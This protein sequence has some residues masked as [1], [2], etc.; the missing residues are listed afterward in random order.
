MRRSSLLAILCA[1]VCALT[2]QGQFFHRFGGGRG[3]AMPEVAGTV[4]L[5]PSETVVGVPCHFVFAFKGGNAVNV[6]Q[7]SGLPNEGIEYLARELEPY[8]DN[9]YRLPVRFLVPMTN[10]TL[11]VAVA[12]MQTVE[13]G[14]G[15]AFVSSFSSSF[16]KRLPPLR[17]DVR[18]LP[19][20][21]RP[22]TFSGAV[23]TKFLLTQTLDRDHVR[24]NDLVTATYHLEFNGYCPSNIWP[25]VDHLSREFKAYDPKEIARTE[26]SY[27]WTQVLVPRTTAATNTPLVSLSYY[28]P[29]VKRYEVAR[30]YPKRLVFVSDQAA[31]TRNTAVVVSEAE[32]KA[33]APAEAGAGPLV[34]RFAPSATSPVVATLPPGTEVRELARANGWRRLETPRAVGW[35]R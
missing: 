10:V 19:E 25:V 2:V 22:Q 34:L 7:V 23:G 8:A 4:R 18:P 5:E 24:P 27:T 15:T 26:T 32:T 3:Q 9:T 31:S 17:I 12:G 11:N 16:Q 14:K 29:H 30:A 35:S 1:C 13:S 20:S 21:G 28:N 33:S 6:Q